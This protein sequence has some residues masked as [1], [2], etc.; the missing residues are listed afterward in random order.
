MFVLCFDNDLICVWIEIEICKIIL[1]RCVDFRDSFHS[2]FCVFLFS[3]LKDFIFTEVMGHRRCCCIVGCSCVEVRE[4]HH[5][6]TGSGAASQRNILLFDST[7]LFPRFVVC[8]L[9][10][11]FYFICSFHGASLRSLQKKTS[12]EHQYDAWPFFRWTGAVAH[13]FIYWFC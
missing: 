10:A 7:T 2:N 4:C 13:L 9:C 8:L 11:L 6:Q 5:C 3:V 12:K 1:W